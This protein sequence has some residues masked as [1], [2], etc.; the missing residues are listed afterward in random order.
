M[1]HPNDDEDFDVEDDRLRE[2]VL[3]P[4]VLTEFTKLDDEIQTCAELTND[5]IVWWS[6]N[7]DLMI[8]SPMSL[9]LLYAITEGVVDKLH[10]AHLA[11]CNSNTSKVLFLR[12]KHCVVK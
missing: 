11:V 3:I 4:D 7:F 10:T 2:H 9:C 1:Q 5:D 12:L 8:K 6:F